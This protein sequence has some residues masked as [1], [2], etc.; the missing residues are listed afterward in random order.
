MSKPL[1]TASRATHLEAQAH[2]PRGPYATHLV[3]D[4]HTGPATQ[5]GLLSL[6]G[7][8]DARGQN[9]HQYLHAPLAAQHQAMPAS[10]EHLE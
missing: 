4:P 7:A 10:S 9:L 1:H 8:H 3:M 2:L 5:R 6:R